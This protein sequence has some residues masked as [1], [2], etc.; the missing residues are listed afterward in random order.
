MMKKNFT[1]SLIALMMSVIFCNANAQSKNASYERGYAPNIEVGATVVTDL[2]TMPSF[3][4]THGYNFGNGLFVGGGTGMAFSKWDRNGI[5]NR[6][7][8][9]V[10][11]DIKYSFM[12]KLASPFVELKAGGVFDCSA[13]GIGY[14]LRPTIGVDV[15][16][17]SFNVGIDIQNC[18]YGTPLF[19]GTG[20]NRAD[21]TYS[22]MSK[23][24]FGNTGLYFGLSFNF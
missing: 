11:A 3:S 9:P 7:T 24:M 6:I 8:V 4:T 18:T 16:K 17:F 14:M 2:G 23:A 1:I 19:T 20:D 22:G 21:Y 12:N 13:V 10:Y 15:W 5:K